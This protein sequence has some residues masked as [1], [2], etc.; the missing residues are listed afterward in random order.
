MIKHSC[1]NH[2]AR[3]ALGI[4][5]L[6]YLILDYYSQLA[7]A[8]CTSEP[9]TADIARD[10]G[11]SESAVRIAL[12]DLSERSLFDRGKVSVLFF[13]ACLGEPVEIKTSTD[14]VIGLFNEM[15][16]TRYSSVT[17]DR[18]VR[19]LLSRDPSLTIKH[20]RMVFD[21]KKETWAS[22]PKMKDY[23][24]PSTILRKSNFFRYLDDARHY[25]MQ[26]IKQ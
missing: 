7:D 14:D 10:L 23:N 4:S 8:E 18:D 1:I 5:A 11:A 25:Y 2:E 13:R 21:H 17:Y 20:F 9:S 16:G 19:A 15:N 12:A 22:D 6:G 26:K 24:N 3:K